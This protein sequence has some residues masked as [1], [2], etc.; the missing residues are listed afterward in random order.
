M[1][2]EVKV[3]LK[4]AAVNFLDKQTNLVASKN[5]S[6]L[7]HVKLLAARPG[8]Q[9]QSTF[10]LPKHVEDNLSALESSNAIC[11]YFSRISQEYPPLNPATLP[12]HIKAKLSDD[13]CKHP[14]LADHIVYEG[15]KKGKK[16]GS[17]PGELPIKILN[18][19]LPKLTAPV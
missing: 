5:N 16:T 1:K 6:W 2:K 13:P 8:D 10:S 18:E 7:R 3:K 9:S 11:E 14:Y 15:L 12:D 17:V 19:F 4:D